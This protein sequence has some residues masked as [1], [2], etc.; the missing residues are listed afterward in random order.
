M[1]GT[2][3]LAHQ[4]DGRRRI[5]PAHAGNTGVAHFLDQ[6]P[7]DHPRTCGEHCLS[8]PTILLTTGSSPHMR[9]TPA[10]VAVCHTSDGIIPAHAGNTA[11]DLSALGTGQDHPRTCGE[12]FR[13][14][15]G[16]ASSLGS[17]P[18]MRGTRT[19]WRYA[20]SAARIIPAH[21]GNTI[22]NINRDAADE[23]HPR[24]CGEHTPDA[25]SSRKMSGSSPHMR[26]TLKLTHL[27]VETE[28]IIPAHAGNTCCV[29]YSD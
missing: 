24:T 6:C 15:A 1:R 8:A 25:W 27:V 14:L 3:P 7:R 2:P 17:S 18:H 20:K 11:D 29:A 21:A 19:R 28:G 16:L 9:G 12:H 4:C 10:H 22:A 23:D 5:I 13:Y 26:G